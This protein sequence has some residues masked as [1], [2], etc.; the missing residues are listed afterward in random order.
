MNKKYKCHDKKLVFISR[1]FLND[2]ACKFLRNFIIYSKYIMEKSKRRFRRK[3][4]KQIATKAY[5][6]KVLH[7]DIETKYWDQGSAGQSF[8]FNA[9]INDISAV[10]QGTTDTSRIGDQFEIRGIHLRY[11]YF[12]VAANDFTNVCRMI[13]F[14][15]MQSDQSAGT[16]VPAEVLQTLGVADAPMS[17]YMNDER[18]VIKVLY[19]KTHCISSNGPAVVVAKKNVNIKF[20]R[21]KVQYTAAGTTGTNKIF[22]LLVSDSNSANLPTARWRTRLLFDDA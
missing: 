19:D 14:Q 5:V 8:T 3:P 16:P 10:P 4:K 7:K 20:A 1:V 12:M 15:Y 13:I 9:V 2:D 11:E 17:P 22:M 6:Q 21:K 18:P